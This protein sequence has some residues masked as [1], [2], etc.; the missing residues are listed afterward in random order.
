MSVYNTGIIESNLNN[1]DDIEELKQKILPLLLDQRSAWTEKI[2]QI[3]SEKTYTCK[4]LAQLCKVSEPTVRK[5]R[6]GSLP[7]SR[8]MYIRIGFA[9]GYNLEEMNVF[10]K[11]Y[12]KCPQ[13]YVKSLEDSV[14]MFV[15]ESEYLTH[16]Y[17]TYLRV[18]DMVK[19]EIR[20][21]TEVHRKA[22]TTVYLSECISNLNSL[23]EM[24]EFA[25][26][27]APSYKQAYSR[28]YSYIIAFLHVNLQNEHTAA[29]DGR[30]ASFHAMATESHWS[31]S[32][33]HCISEIRNK[34][35]FPLRHKIISL[36]L[37]L[38]MDTDAIN[39]MLQHA[40]MEPL[41]AKN[42]IEA[43]IMWAIEEAKL[44][45]DD[46]TIIQDGSSDLFDFVKG[47][48]VQLDLAEESNYLIEDL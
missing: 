5:W 7:Q 2:E 36:G 17:E 41:Y 24:I 40:Q 16:T 23:E 20:G 34:R 4:Q 37:H 26:I 48:L 44:S 9:A 46:D 19:Q 8:D 10:L 18:L 30:R 42:P 21:V 15:L 12:G 47:V 14:C 29:G 6:N 3:L 39:R 25:K 43:S 11:R 27:H 22:Y 28:L 45:S 31:S 1:C 33:R 35:W 13:L 32:L 38:N